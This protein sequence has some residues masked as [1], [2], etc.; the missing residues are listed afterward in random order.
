MYVCVRLCMHAYL[1]DWSWE[2][3]SLCVPAWTKMLS[4]KGH[5]HVDQC[6]NYGH[7]T[8]SRKTGPSHGGMFKLSDA[9][10]NSLFQQLY[11]FWNLFINLFS[12]SEITFFMVHINRNIA[13]W[14]RVV[15]THYAKHIR[16]GLAVTE[17]SECWALKE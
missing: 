3:R 6:G 10:M 4:G 12:V 11:Y 15:L 7:W 9:V 17:N 13:S 2:R 8:V 1:N 14:E 5:L 16:P